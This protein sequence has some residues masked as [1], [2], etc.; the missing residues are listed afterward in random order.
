MVTIERPIVV[1]VDEEGRPVGRAEK[2]AA[3]QPPGVLH[4]AFSVVLYRGDGRLLL[5]RRAATKYHFP[6]HWA[7]ACCS[8]P[9]PG[10]DVAASAAHRVVEE[11]GVECALAPAGSF[12]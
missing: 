11:L 9:S 6:L 2:L 7:N 10:E 12:V 4:L 8:H 3:H 1:L 5:Q